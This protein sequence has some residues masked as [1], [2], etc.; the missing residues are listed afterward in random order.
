VQYIAGKQTLS[1][2]SPNSMDFFKNAV[3]DKEST[4]Y[5]NLQRLLG[6][7]QAIGL[8]FNDEKTKA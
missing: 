7:K 2:L 4:P 1:L 5:I 6:R 8:W 3:L